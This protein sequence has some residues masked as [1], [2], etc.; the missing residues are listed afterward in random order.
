MA[1]HY[2]IC[3]DCD[4]TITDT[5]SKGVHKCPKCGS[6]MRW[7]LDNLVVGNDMYGETKYS[8]SLAISPTQVGEHKRLFPDIKIDDQCRPGFDSFRQHD[9]YLKKCGFVKQ[10]QKIKKRGKRIA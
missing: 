8:D 6:D 1:T 5:T 3:D 7:D 10:P 9:N 2:F 4:I